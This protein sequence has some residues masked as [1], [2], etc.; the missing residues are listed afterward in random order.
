MGSL[1]RADQGVGITHVVVSE[2]NPRRS[3]TDSTSRNLEVM[4]PAFDFCIAVASARRSEFQMNRME[5]LTAKRGQ[6]RH[7]RASEAV[8]RSA[9]RRQG[10][11]EITVIGSLAKGDF[12]SHSDVDL[13]VRGPIELKLRRLIERLVAGNM[14]SSGFL[15]IRFS[16]TIS[17]EI[18]SRS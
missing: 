14:R 5:A 7:E 17:P 9:C 11:N 18:A 8:A 10:W 3:S 13:L 4:S 1:S 12:R 2:P 15:T 16:R 6:T